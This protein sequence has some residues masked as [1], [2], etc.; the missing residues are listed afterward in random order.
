MACLTPKRRFEG[1]DQRLHD[2]AHLQH[3]RADVSHTLSD[4]L[5]SARD[6]DGPLRGVW[7]HVSG[8]L[9]LGACG[10]YVS[11][12]ERRQ[13]LVTA[14]PSAQ[15][16]TLKCCF[17]H[18]RKLGWNVLA[19]S[20]QLPNKRQCVPWYLQRPHKYSPFRVKIRTRHVYWNIW[21]QKKTGMCDIWRCWWVVLCLFGCITRNNKKTIMSC[22]NIK[23]K[24]MSTSLI[25]LIF[26]PPFPISDPHWL[27]GKTRRRV[28]GG[29]LVTL[30]FVIAAVISWEKVQKYFFLRRL[31]WRTWNKVGMDLAHFLAYL[32]KLLCNHGEGSENSLCG[33]SDGHDSLWRRSL[34]Y[35]DAGAAL[36]TKLQSYAAAHSTP[37]WLSQNDANLFSH[38]LHCFSFLESYRRKSA[39]LVP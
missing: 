26:E 23:T 39:L 27:P 5:R 9:N 10:L 25:S 2:G 20:E 15:S 36:Q 8:H 18:S 17:K 13:R 21:K 7:Q 30:L 6:G 12:Q 14:E 34:G 33:A 3:H 1:E 28:T 24:K 22:I 19:C 11:R 31:M 4:G 29:L 32:L 35:V 38:F 37:S 16:A